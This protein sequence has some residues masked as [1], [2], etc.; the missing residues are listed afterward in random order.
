M[1]IFVLQSI[2]KGDTMSRRKSKMQIRRN[3]Y[4]KYCCIYNRETKK[5]KQ[6]PIKLAPITETK[7]A[8]ERKS[9]VENIFNQL[10]RTNLGHTIKDYQ[11]KWMTEDGKSGFK[12]PLTM[13]EGLDIFMNKRRVSQATIEI[14][15]ICL[16]HWID[17]LGETQPIEHIQSKH[18]IGYVE[19]KQDRGRSNTSIN[20]D[21]RTIRTMMLYL[22]EIEE[23]KSTPSF[24]KAISMCPIND[25]D[26]IYITEQ[27][28]N[29]IMTEDWLLIY[30]PKRDYYRRVFKMY[31]DLGVRLSEPFKATIIGNYLSI[32]KMKNSKARK[33]RINEEHKDIIL[34]MQHRYE[35]KPTKDHIKNYSKVFKKILR[36][37][38]I[39]EK[40]HLHSLRHSYGLR[41]RIE[42]NGNIQKVQREMGHKEYKT[43]EKYQRCEEH[44][45]RDDF[46][47]L[48]HLLESVENGAISSYSTT[49]NSTTSAHQYHESPREMN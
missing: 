9:E 19:L 44:L 33:I 23:I 32:P 43:T 29:R 8:I 28:L 46:P 26:P 17:Y 15:L 38:K 7:L 39:D 35:L 16:T 14:N 5:T 42:T 40:K 37:L 31:W 20:M 48:A 22:K 24:K 12:T 36:W 18:L 2:T 10:K 11:F 1:P 25:E 41:R 27:E 21:L 47:S 45:L 34:E 3:W 6:I 30:T 49:N 13:K 4:Y